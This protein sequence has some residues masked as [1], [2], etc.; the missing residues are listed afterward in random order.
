MSDP[1]AEQRAASER[2]ADL[3]QA[4]KFKDALK[5]FEQAADGP[6]PSLRHRARTHATIC[7]N[8]VDADEARVT[9]AEDHYNLAVQLINSRR[10]DDA[11]AHLKNA[12]AK[13]KD[14]GH[15]HYAAALLAAL[16]R[17]ADRAYASLKKAIE[18]DP[19]NRFLARG[20]S[21]LSAVAGD[22]RIAELLR[23]EAAAEVR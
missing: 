5:L 14:A 7:R 17:D 2:A 16:R 8:R 12:L 22:A 4:R 20:D 6:D 23:G 13:A 10:L 9:S 11:E 3:F 18:L 1:R 21:D 15:V 19:A